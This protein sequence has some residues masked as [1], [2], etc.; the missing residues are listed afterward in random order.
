VPLRDPFALSVRD[1]RALTPVSISL[2]PSEASLVVST[3]QKDIF[4]I[5]LPSMDLLEDEAHT[6]LK[7]HARTHTHT[8]THTHTY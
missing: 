3:D 5:N 8:H 6:H 1:A 4:V 7:T 2:S